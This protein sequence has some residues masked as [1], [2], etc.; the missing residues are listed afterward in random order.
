MTGYGK[1][2]KPNPVSLA[3]HSPWKSLARFPHFHRPDDDLSF[4]NH[5]P[6]GAF[7]GGSL[8]SRLQAHSSMRK[9]WPQPFDVWDPAWASVQFGVGKQHGSKLPPGAKRLLLCR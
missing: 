6:K 8:R 7:S 2:G 9:C 5:R 3:S 1:R 4:T